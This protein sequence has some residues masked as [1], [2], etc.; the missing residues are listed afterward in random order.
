ME[1][2]KD[3]RKKRIK[4]FVRMIIKVL[5]D[6]GDSDVLN[7]FLSALDASETLILGHL[8]LNKFIS[9]KDA[10]NSVEGA[11]KVISKAIEKMEVKK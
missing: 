6:R 5:P 11:K 7:D 1:K 10:I 9:K 3:E 4:E 8:V 2:G